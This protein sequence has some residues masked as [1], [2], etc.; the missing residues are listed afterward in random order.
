MR[1]FSSGFNPNQ[2]RVLRTKDLHAF[3]FPHRC[4]IF[5]LSALEPISD[6]EQNP[7]TL[8][9]ADG[10]YE[11]SYQDVPCFFSATPETDQGSVLGRVKVSNIFTLDKFVFPED[12][13]ILD[14]W[15][16]VFLS[17]GNNYQNLYS[18]QGNPESK[19]PHPLH[20]DNQNTQL[21][22]GKRMPTSSLPVGLVIRNA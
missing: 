9:V 10:H 3:Y 16:I 15:Y 6:T 14:T 13:T 11:L 7:S 1:L 4:D 20:L 19:N 12:V 22:Y 2:S 5:K 8:R 17:K 21:V 18:V